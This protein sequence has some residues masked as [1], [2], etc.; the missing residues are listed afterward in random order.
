M[1]TNLSSYYYNIGRV[2]KTSI[3]SRYFNRKFD[4]NQKSTVNPAYY[5]KVENYAGKKV[6]FSFWDTAGQEIFN[7]L[8]TIYYQGAV[9]GLIV[10]DV[11][12]FDTFKK[13][14]K[15]VNELQEIVGKDISLVIAGNKYDLM[16]KDDLVK[17]REVVDAYCQQ[18]K[19]THFYTSAKSGDG[20]NETF[21]YIV[22]EILSKQKFDAPGKKKG[23]IKLAEDTQKKEKKKCC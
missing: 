21:D 23:G 1:I 3:L 9:G 10:Y 6:K 12:N 4:E 8:N 7:A 17:Q 5:E 13:V 11:S 15:W 22:K 20:L 2:G 16:L 14:Q 18:E 19:I